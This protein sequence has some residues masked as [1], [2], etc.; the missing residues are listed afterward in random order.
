MHLLQPKRFKVDSDYKPV[1]A[2][3]LGNSFPWFA[4]EIAVSNEETIETTPISIMRFPEVNSS[5][6]T[7]DIQ[8][9]SKVNSFFKT[10][11]SYS[12]EDVVAIESLT[13]GQ[14]EN[15]SWFEY[16]RGA[17][18]ASRAHSILTFMNK[19]KSNSNR[20]I[21]ES[22]RYDRENMKHV[23]PIKVASLKYGVQHEKDAINQFEHFAKMDSNPFVR[24]GFTKE[25]KC[26]IND[27]NKPYCQ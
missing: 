24:I 7:T 25:R 21:L 23:P 8:Y 19:G 10:M 11:S 16:K 9:D 3:S 1:V 15:I 27:A 18:S 13:K 2:V 4:P 12:Q 22:V 26:F 6:S 17:I 14:H 20:L 5:P